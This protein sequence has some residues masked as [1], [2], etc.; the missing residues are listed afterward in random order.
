MSQLVGKPLAIT[1]L[2]AI[3][4]SVALHLANIILISRPKKT[5]TVEEKSF[6]AEILRRAEKNIISSYFKKKE[7]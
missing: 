3:M 5:P 4:I 2:I 1:G 7:E 6:G